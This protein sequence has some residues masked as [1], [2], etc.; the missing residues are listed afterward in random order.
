MKALL[1]ILHASHDGLID[2]ILHLL[3]KSLK[4]S[5]HMLLNTL[6]TSSYLLLKLLPYI[7]KTKLHLL[8]N[9]LLHDGKIRIKETI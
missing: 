2:L 7:L 4:T 3:P 5:I 1:N 9:V 8:P 6:K